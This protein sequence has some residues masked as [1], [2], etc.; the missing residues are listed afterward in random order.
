MNAG[1]LNESGNAL[2]D[3]GDF[4]R[5]QEYYA[6][7]IAADPRFAEAHNNLGQA[8]RRQGKLAEARAALEQA[9]ILD[10]ELAI[11]HYN[12][13]GLLQEAGD[14]TGAAA[15]Y[16]KALDVY[17]QF[18]RAR[19]DWAR[20]LIDQGKP[21]DARTLL[22]H[23]VRLDPAAPNFH[24]YL[25]NL[26]ADAG[27]LDAARAGYEQALAVQP[28]HHEA[29][30]GLARALMRQG[31]WPQARTL[32]KRACERGGPH[33]AFLSYAICCLI[34]GD[35]ADGWKFLERRLD[36]P[37]PELQF[38]GKRI[39]HLSGKPFWNGEP[40][41]GRRLLVWNEQGLGDTL[42]ML[43]YLPLLRDKGAGRVLSWCE[44]PMR[45]L[46][47]ALPGVDEI[48][49]TPFPEVSTFDC[50]CSIM[51]LPFLFGTD[52]TSI[53]GRVPYLVVLDESREFWRERMRDLQGLRVGLTWAGRKENSLSQFRTV[54]YPLLEPLLR[55]SG[56]DFVSL[57]KDRTGQGPLPANVADWMDECNDLM[58]T[59]ALV[60][61]LD[62]V[63]S[64]DTGVAHL[65]GALG[66]PVWLL[67]YSGS[68]WRWMLE[69]TDSP[70]YPGMTIYRQ[71]RLH[72]W[73][74]VIGRVVSDLSRL[75]A[76]R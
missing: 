30:L 70:W 40:L 14:V 52:E 48:V 18:E 19:L 43:R 23:G 3:A 13:G 1:E 28:E 45:R 75:A 36:S 41:G 57:Q 6:K 49:G 29:E 60:S 71:P 17:P 39:A 72:D 22:L 53:P 68:D 11:A 2:F 4:G 58:D 74:A 8:L 20:L 21:E 15:R 27:N 7:S 33:E 63:I 44:A 64:I 54:P 73:Q 26:D 76:A 10:P 67:C 62:L 47:G 59:A 24:F 12:L 32:F 51:S 16:G 35:F 37:A 56:V 5:A 69:R 46:I 34:L 65:A 61:N 31:K 42:M 9:V 25:G 38:I 55:V 50:H 66:K